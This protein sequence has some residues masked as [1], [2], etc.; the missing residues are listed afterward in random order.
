L[1]T[2]QTAKQ[3]QDRL[4][5][6]LIVEDDF[7][8]RNLLKKMLSEMGYSVLE[9]ENGR[10][11]W[12]MI[13]REPRRLM[14][15]DW[16]MPEMD[17]LQ[18]CRKI[19]T[20]SFPF[21]IY[22]IMLTAKDHKKDL[23]NVFGS[24]ADDYISKPFDPEELRARVLTG[25][26]IIE[27]EVS[28]TTLQTALIES[29][30][31]LRV[32]L[33]ALPEQIVSLNSDFTIISANKAFVRT[34]PENVAEIIGSNFLELDNRNAD[35]NLAAAVIK[36]LVS[37]VFKTG[38]SKRS[39]IKGEDAIGLTTFRQTTGF[40]VE[41]ESKHVDQ[42]VVVIQDITTVGVRPNDPKTHHSPQVESF[43]S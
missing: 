1:R 20:T 21:Y 30:N 23:V 15:T 24:G 31:K 3:D 18:L 27:L 32:V 26:R 36:P 25:L 29:R 42:V 11:A 39:L 4:V 28:Y 43:H 14:I 10:Q 6:I 38:I 35:M 8:S 34:L 19:R 16:M 9:A 13:Q 41:D 17:G 22:I 33:D 2:E 7:I 40:P 5:E 12:N 37:E